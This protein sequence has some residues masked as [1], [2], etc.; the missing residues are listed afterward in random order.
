VPG[1]PWKAV[2]E[3]QL[4]EHRVGGDGDE[5][6]HQ[7]QAHARPMRRGIR[8]GDGPAE[9]VAGQHEVQ[10]QPQMYAWFVKAHFVERGEIQQIERADVEHQG[11]D[12]MAHATHRHAGRHCHDAARG[13][14]RHTAQQQGT[15]RTEHQRDGCEHP[16]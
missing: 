15:R 10:V 9:Q 12:R 3:H 1:I 16:Q 14:H 11:R 8:A 5:E 6:H 7:A 2:G 4:A 13:G